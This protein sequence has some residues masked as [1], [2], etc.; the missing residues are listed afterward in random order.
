MKKIPL[1]LS[2][3]I[4]ASMT[5]SCGNKDRGEGLGHLYNAALE[6][7]PKS[8][9]PQY[10]SDPSSNTVIKNLYSGLMKTD[11]NGNVSCCNAKKYTVSPDGLTYTFELRTD[12]YWF[13]DENSNDIFEKNEYF[14]V[15]AKDYV[16]AFQRLLDPKMQSPYA[17]Y[18]SCISGGKDIISGNRSPEEA[19]VRA[20]GD[21]TLEITLDHPS[22]EFLKLLALAPA[23]PCN[24]DFFES[25]KGRYGLDDKSVMCNGAFY[26]R[27]WYYDPYGNHNIL[28]MKKFDVNANP[29][30]QVLPSY[31]SFS[32]EKDEE[33]VR[34]CFK[35]D[36]IE[37]FTTLSAS[38][39]SSKYSVSDK[40]AVTL[41]IIFNQKEGYFV[42]S[43][44]RRALALSIDRSRLAEELSDD[45]EA[46]CGIIPPAAEVAGK[47]YREQVSDK[48]FE[49]YKPEEA[50]KCVQRA[51]E[52][53]NVGSFN[54]LKILICSDSVDS[55]Y[56]HLL[57]QQWQDSLGIYIGIDEVK[58]DEFYERLENGDYSLALYPMHPELNSPA[59]VFGA[60]EHDENLIKAS[61]GKKRSQE[62]MECATVAEVVEKC[63]AFE[64]ELLDIGAFVPV[65]Y[66][67]CY[68]VAS[69][70]NDD[71]IYDPFSG[72]VD[73][74]IARN[75][76]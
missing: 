53:L 32:I 41:G 31:L 25:T 48:V 46:A 45:V 2:A 55:G 58:Q 22:A 1:I 6:G 47:K 71:I 12:N 5:V 39:N 11:P 56:V 10:A 73:F 30:F 42:S 26:M 38:Y 40:R 54:N 64:R 65:F 23:S 21:Y 70:D 66:K 8:L 34:Q 44:L 18:Y 33:D 15:T 68:L 49:N 37:C 72:A 14:P 13:R 59:A 61:D 3:A 51:K 20:T 16:F 60:F 57:T 24:K 28:Y 74:R 29:E 19:G 36:E 69:D 76:S 50:E 35:D 9:D 17:G 63:T 27:Q 7:N 43:D 67:S 62:I 52:A 75:Y 4:C